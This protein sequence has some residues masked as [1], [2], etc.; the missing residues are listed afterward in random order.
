M[1]DAGGIQRDWRRIVTRRAWVM[2]TTAYEATVE[3]GQVKILG[4]VQL[5]ER[6]TVYVVVPG[7]QEAVKF[8]VGSPR[9]A[10]P[11]RAADFAMEVAEESRDAGL[12]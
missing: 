2:K 5:P 9:L 1:L 3:N 10:Q 7:E 8:H 4:A 11:E 12:R 6:A